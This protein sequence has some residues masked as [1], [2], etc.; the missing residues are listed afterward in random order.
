VKRRGVDPPDDEPEASG[1]ELEATDDTLPAERSFAGLAPLFVFA[2]LVLFSLTAWW[3]INQPP[4]PTAEAP[5]PGT[6]LRPALT[7]LPATGGLNTP[8]PQ[9]QIGIIAGH[10]AL[11]PLPNGDVV[12]DPDA[13]FDSGARCDDLSV[14]EADLTLDIAKR[15]AAELRQTD[16][17]EVEVLGEFDPRLRGYFGAA[18]ISL[19]ADAC[20]KSF[21]GYKVARLIESTLPA[22]ED[23]LVNCIRDR[24]Q[25]VTGLN[26]H[27]NTITVDMQ[28]YH[29]F[30]EIALTT[31]GAILEMGFLREDQA[32]LK[33]GDLPVKG[34]ADSVRCFL[35]SR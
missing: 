15:V 26:E 21:S 16:K 35:A 17:L 28:E 20:L 3:I 10:N 7:T 8:R 4:L 22:V 23:R 9:T 11:K 31:P 25:A 33:Q 19:H 34:I 18:L 30:R 27:R 14:M 1:D 6:S 29:A 13:L 12:R 32:L 5:A 24:Y 2:A